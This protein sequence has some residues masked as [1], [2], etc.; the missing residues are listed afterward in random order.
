MSRRTSSDRLL[1]ANTKAI[2]RAVK[3]CARAK[4]KE[5]RIEGTRGLVLHVLPTGCATWYL[6][7]DVPRGNTRRRRKLK[8]GRADEISLAH[9]TAAAD[10]MRPIIRD[11]ADPVA[12]KTETRRA[13]TFADLAKDRIEK[14]EL[15][16]PST[17]RDYGHI[18]KKDILPALG[19]KAAKSITRDDIIVLLDRISARGANRRAD[20]ARTVISSVFGFGIDR[21]QVDTN[22]TAGLRKRHDYQ[23]RNV[24]A[25]QGAIRRLWSAMG[26]KRPCRRRSSK[27]F[28]WRC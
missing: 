14:G 6:H 1:P 4:S 9:A 12:Q 8:L 26:G 25:D 22:P 3:E 7:Y 13:P 2:A 24:I 15:L 19:A 28:D 17:R 21:G 27:L 20:T 11:G 5:Y 16:R 23:P 10:R 18:L